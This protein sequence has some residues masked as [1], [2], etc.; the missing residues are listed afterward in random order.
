M[1]EANNQREQHATKRRCDRGFTLIEML[2][3]LIIMALLAGIATPRYFSTITNQQLAAVQ[4]KI[5]TDLAYAQRCAR[6]KSKKQKIQFDVLNDSY[7]LKKIPDLDR[8]GTEFQVQL[9][10]GPYNA[11]IVSANF[12]GPSVLTYD[13]YGVPVTGGSIVVRVR[14][15]DLTFTISNAS[16]TGDIV[17]TKAMAVLQ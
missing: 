8:P 16:G 10:Q 1:F 17:V 7:T 4:R 3:V 13:A 9:D 12:G 11:T 14:D 5:Q 15:Q 6:L 2:F